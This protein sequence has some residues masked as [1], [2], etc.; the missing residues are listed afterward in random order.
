MLKR[1]TVAVVVCT[2]LIPA[3]ARASYRFGFGGRVDPVSGGLEF[4][5]FVPLKEQAALFV[6]P[7][8]VG[9]FTYD[10]GS[11][12]IFYSAGLRGGVM[13]SQNDWLS[14]YVGLGFGS[15][16][17]IYES[18][19]Y[20]GLGGRIY[21]GAGMA[22]LEIFAEAKEHGLDRFRIELESGFFYR[23]YMSSTR[24]GTFENTET[25]LWFP[26]IGFGIS[27]NW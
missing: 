16:G 17:E 9:V 12:D 7:H 22:P 24:Y 8:G 2:L 13:F 14:P 15:T 4:R 18:S 26:D 6:A 20:I 19:S 11:Q 23:L 5:L 1:I 27:Y 21:V 25:R 10:E 3:I